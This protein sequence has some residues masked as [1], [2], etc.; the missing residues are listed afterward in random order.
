MKTGW[1][2]RCRQVQAYPTGER[3]EDY[4]SAFE[5]F[6]RDNRDHLTRA[7]LRALQTELDR[8]G[9]NPTPTLLRSAYASARQVDVAAHIIGF[10]RA[11]ATQE[12][13]SPFE[14]RVDAALGRL[15]GS[16]PWTPVQKRWLEQLSKAAQERRRAGRKPL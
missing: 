15:L 1:S 7:E 5:R 2:A 16:R 4:L 6:V 9:F 10:L 3:P 14:A 8:E 12:L 11:A 13:P